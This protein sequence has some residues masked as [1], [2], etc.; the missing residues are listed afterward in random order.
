MEVWS[1]TNSEDV[2]RRA[3]GRKDFRESQQNGK[4][5]ETLGGGKKRKSSA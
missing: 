2:P 5:G 3:K 4:G 1:V